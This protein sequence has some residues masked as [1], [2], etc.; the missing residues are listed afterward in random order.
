MEL[1]MCKRFETNNATATV[2]GVA[3]VFVVPAQLSEDAHDL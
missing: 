2:A 1:N 3:S